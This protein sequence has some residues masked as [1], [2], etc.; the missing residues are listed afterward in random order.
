ML[1]SGDS[2]TS[3]DG[4]CEVVAVGEK[5]SLHMYAKQ[6]TET[7]K[8]SGFDSFLKKITYYAFAL[9]VFGLVVVLG[10][11]VFYTETMPLTQFFLFAV[12][13]LVGVVPEA[14]PLIITIILSRVSLTLA[15]N[16]VIVKHLPALENLGNMNYL[17]TDKTGTITSNQLHVE[18]CTADEPLKDLI[19]AIARSAYTRT[20]M[21]TVFDQAI[22]DAFAD[23]QEP[24]RVIVTHADPYNPERG[25]SIYTMSTGVKILRGVYTAIAPL[26]V[27]QE[28]LTKECE[29]GEAKGLRVI[30]C[31]IAS[32]DANLCINSGLIFFEDPL[33]E[34]AKQIYN[35]LKK[36]NVETKIL[37]GDSVNVAEYIA[38][39]IDPNI[40]AKESVQD[41]SN[42]ALRDGEHTVY[43]K[44]KP[45]DKLT[46]LNTYLAKGVVGFMGDGIND[47]LALKR[48]DVGFAVNNASDVARQSA[49]IVSC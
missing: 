4:V 15:K 33:K 26:C 20:P 21:D 32:A 47:A 12:A 8:S 24:A 16:K 45:V 34:D 3:G 43:A 7:K 39:K 1:Y 40:N 29:A 41:M 10:Y 13:M 37:T 48:A 38:E 2:I 17:C 11:S 22:I 49:D 28:S 19:V 44:C 42:Q 46:I 23:V 5:N 30:A 25:Y 36:I 6:I 27:A 35:E 14:L 31:A 18:H 9:A